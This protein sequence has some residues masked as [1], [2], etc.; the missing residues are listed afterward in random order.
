MPPKLPK[1]LPPKREDY[2]KIDLDSGAKPL[3]IGPYRMAL[4]K[5]KKLRKQLKESLNTGFIQ[6]SK[7]PYDTS[8][9]FQKKH[10]GSLRM[11]IQ[12]SD[13]KEQVAH[14]THC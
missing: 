11:S 10:D 6:P 8:I 7:A 2:H 3:A 1:R 13:S 14:P 12:Q 4:S 5:L 9:L